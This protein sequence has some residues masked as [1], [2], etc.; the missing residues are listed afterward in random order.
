MKFGKS[1]N[2]IVMDNIIEDI[3]KAIQSE[4]ECQELLVT[5]GSGHYT[6]EVTSVAFA[7]KNKIQRQRMVYKAIW[8]L[9]KG[10]QAPLHAVDKMTCLLPE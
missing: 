1:K 6:I 5:G 2:E 3:E 4:I 9:M 8:E 10:D 7:G